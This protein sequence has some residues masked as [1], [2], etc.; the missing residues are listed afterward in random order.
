MS[1]THPHPAP[2]SVPIPLVLTYSKSTHPLPPVILI[3]LVFF[4][5]FH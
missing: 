1:L 5:R 2:I 4:E 3:K